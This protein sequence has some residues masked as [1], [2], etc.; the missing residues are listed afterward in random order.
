MP[1]SFRIR[2]LFFAFILFM[3]SGIHQAL[4]QNVE[5]EQLQEKLKMD[6]EFLSDSI[7]NGRKTGSS[8]ASAAALY[9][10]HRL[11]SNGYEVRYNVFETSSG[12]M[13]RNI[14][15]RIPGNGAK[16]SILLM[17]AYDGLGSMG[18]KL[19]P[20]A[21]SNASGAA[22]LLS[23]ADNLKDRDD[24]VFAFVDGH[25]ANMSG[26]EALRT[27][28]KKTRLKMVVNLNT[29]GSTLAPPVKFWKNY[30]IAL[31][32]MPYQ[33]SLEKANSNAALRLYY[34]YYGSRSFTDL[35][36]RRISDHKVFF[37]RNI[38]VLM[39]TSGITMNTN[40]ESDDS[41]SLDYG[42]FA[43]RVDLILRWIIS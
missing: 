5:L 39:F 38:P 3:L 7:C 35:F 17:A 10:I 1:F 15:A 33:R 31:G 42:I 11:R 21:D 6:V 36:Y 40:R 27:Y 30:L 25:N 20:G 28:L 19:Y 2:K 18:G 24:I 26:A 22:A 16:A 23:L 8:G 41:A 32:G 29:L 34:D 43:L 14:V 9:I 12:S 4:A 37:D 13:G